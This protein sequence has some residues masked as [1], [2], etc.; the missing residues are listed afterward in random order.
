ML[1]PGSIIVEAINYNGLAVF[2]LANV[3][4][5]AVNLSVRT[6][7]VSPAV[8]F[9]VC[10]VYLLIVTGAATYAMSAGIQLKC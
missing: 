7:F 2:L 9:A 1:H 4:T 5:G 10:L 3:L 6:L 8:A